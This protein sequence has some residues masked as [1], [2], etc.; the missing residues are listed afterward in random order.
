ML[1]QRQDK[2]TLYNAGIGS[3]GMVQKKPTNPLLIVL[4][5]IWFLT[6]E[7]LSHIKETP[8]KGFRRQYYRP[9]KND[10]RSIVYHRLLKQNAIFARFPLR[11]N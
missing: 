2:F 1:Q 8:Q 3:A 10:D 7:S 9:V 4:F 5:D 6:S 11:A